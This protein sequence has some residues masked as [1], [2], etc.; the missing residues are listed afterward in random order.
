MAD[1]DDL[2]KTIAEDLVV[3]KYKMSAEI[4]QSK[5][6]KESASRRIALVSR[7]IFI[8]GCG[9]LSLLCM[10][11]TYGVWLMTNDNDPGGNRSP[12]IL[13]FFRRV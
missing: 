11:L 5:S 4:T 6:K 9:S 2:E 8:C 12:V 7:A 3:T 10:L 13:S 1:K